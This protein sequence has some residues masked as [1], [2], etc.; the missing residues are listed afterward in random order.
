[1]AKEKIE[2]N[3]LAEEQYRVSIDVGEMWSKWSSE[4]QV[5]ETI[6]HI[7]DGADERK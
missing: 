2:V 6:I 1:M 4:D 5:A 3:V 7:G